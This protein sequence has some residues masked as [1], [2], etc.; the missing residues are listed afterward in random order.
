MVK[1]GAGGKARRLATTGPGGQVRA[2]GEVA[3]EL[4][5]AGQFGA[6]SRQWKRFPKSRKNGDESVADPKNMYEI[7]L[8]H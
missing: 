4:R 3:R 6:S 5:L 1:L 8:P 2:E 7:L